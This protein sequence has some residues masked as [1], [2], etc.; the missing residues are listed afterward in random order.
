MW[1]R[2]SEQ[3]VSLP[4]RACLGERDLHW[5]EVG[6]WK[7]KL[8]VEKKELPVDIAIKQLAESPM[9]YVVRNIQHTES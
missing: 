7:E 1:K 6:F 5:L 4:D 8:D 9:M 3:N 2:R